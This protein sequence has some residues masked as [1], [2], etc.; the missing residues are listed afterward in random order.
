M[1]VFGYFHDAA[2]ILLLFGLIGFGVQGGFTGLY[3][4]AARLYPTELRST[5]VGWGI[6]AGRIG[7]VIGPIL[8]GVFIGLGLTMTENFMV[9]TI[10]LFIAGLATIAIRSVDIK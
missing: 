1:M 6:G 10:P 8:G 5:G 9:F 2:L 4:V 7:A 3:T